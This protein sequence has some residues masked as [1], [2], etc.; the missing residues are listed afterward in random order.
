MTMMG[1]A[2]GEPRFAQEG[3]MRPFFTGKGRKAGFRSIASS[4][5]PFPMLQIF[6]LI[7]VPTAFAG[8]PVF[9]P[10]GEMFEGKISELHFPRTLV[11]HDGEKTWN[12]NALGSGLRTKFR[13]KVYEGVLYADENAALEGEWKDLASQT[14]YA[15]HIELHFRRGVGGDK[16]I[17]AFREDLEKTIPDERKESLKKD[18]GTFLSFFDRKCEKGDVETLTWLP[19][20]GLLVRF[21]D[22]DLGVVD[23]AELSTALFLIW[24][25][26]HPINDGM[27]RDLFRLIPRK[28]DDK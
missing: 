24:I 17:N 15:A 10:G 28:D 6:M 13:I 23:N 18:E 3:L 26:D 27:K 20:T 5:L 12:L 2:V 7:L 25:G 22:E 21:N 8:S 11:I 16:I 19:G 1:R 9:E 14:E 4:L